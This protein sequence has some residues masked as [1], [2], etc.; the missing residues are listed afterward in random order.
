MNWGLFG[1][2][3]AQLCV[4]LRVVLHRIVSNGFSLDLYYLAFPNDRR[5]TKYTVYGI[6]VIEFGQTILVAYDM[7]ATFGYG[8]GDMDALTSVHIYWLAGTIMG[9]VGVQSI[10]YLSSVT[11]KLS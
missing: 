9:A 3:S 1:T 2:L 6:Y 4:S 10:C 5:F 7:F 11:Y 8:F